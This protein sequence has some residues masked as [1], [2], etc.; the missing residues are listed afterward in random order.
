[1]RMPARSE[2][3]PAADPLAAAV[4]GWVLRFTLAALV[5]ALVVISMSGQA[6]LAIASV[7]GLL[8]I[9]IGAATVAAPGG[10]AAGM[11]LLVVL[12]IQIASGDGAIGTRVIWLAALAVGVHLV[13]AVCS[14]VPLYGRI[15]LRALRPAAIRAAAALAALAVLVLA[16]KS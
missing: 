7:G 12:G 5:V 8:L 11:L 14:S 3:A 2:V 4:P 13:A 16:L 1:M 10:S 15:P 9:V 6:H